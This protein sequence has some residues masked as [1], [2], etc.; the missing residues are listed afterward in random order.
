VKINLSNGHSLSAGG[1]NISHSDTSGKVNL[2]EE[3]AAFLRS[4]GIQPEIEKVSSLDIAPF[5][6]KNEITFK[7][8]DI[9]K[10]ACFLER[11]AT[12]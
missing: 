7:Y 10:L 12:G 1:Y 8:L 2:A 11:R 9:V 4:R 3:V 5:C 6:V